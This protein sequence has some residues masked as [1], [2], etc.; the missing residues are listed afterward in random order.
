MFLAITWNKND[1]WGHTSKLIPTVDHPTGK[2]CDEVF[3]LVTPGTNS[4]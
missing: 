1:D 3:K 4:R 2:D